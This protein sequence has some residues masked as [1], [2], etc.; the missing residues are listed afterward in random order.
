MKHMKLIALLAAAMMVQGAHASSK[1][2]DAKKVGKSAAKVTWHAAQTATGG[3]A[4][5]ADFMMLS[6]G[7]RPFRENL[8]KNK[9][10]IGVASVAAITLLNEGLRGLNRELK[11]TGLAK[12][13]RACVMKRKK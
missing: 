12:K 13:V 9:W 2:D 10:F 5:F 3:F 1:M 8:R 4:V 7:V 11:L 6:E